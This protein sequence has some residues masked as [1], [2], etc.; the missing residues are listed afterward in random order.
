M[1]LQLQQYIYILDSKIIAQPVV[2]ALVEVIILVFHVVVA[3]ILAH[4]DLALVYEPLPKL[5]QEKPPPTRLLL[6]L[7]LSCPQLR[8]LINVHEFLNLLLLLRQDV[9]LVVQLPAPSIIV[10]RPIKQFLVVEDVPLHVEQLLREL[11]DMHVRVQQVVKQQPVRREPVHRLV[12]LRR[13]QDLH[14]HPTVHRLPQCRLEY[15]HWVI[16]RLH[17]LDVIFRVLYRLQDV[18]LNL[19]V[20]WRVCLVELVGRREGVEVVEQLLVILAQGVKVYPIELCQV[21]EVLL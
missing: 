18:L 15:P 21:H 2:P 10:E 17:Y 20:E 16:V 14:L 4:E 9:E 3:L 8:L 6:V 1:I 7:Y 13:R 5:Y 11:V 12:T 19:P